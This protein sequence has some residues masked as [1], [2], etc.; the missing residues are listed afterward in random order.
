MGTDLKKSERTE[1]IDYLRG[2]SCIAVYL[3]HFVCIFLP[4]LMWKNSANSVIDNFWLGTPFNAITNGNSAVQFF[5]VVSGFLTAK[6]YYE[7]RNKSVNSSGL[8]FKILKLIEITTPAILFSFILM[9]F[10]RMYHIQAAKI[11]ARCHFVNCYNSF[12]PTY[13]SLVKD[14]F[15]VIV[16]NSK[17]NAPLGFMAINL[18]GGVLAD[19][20]S[21]AV[22]KTTDRKNGLLIYFIIW[23][24][25]IWNDQ[26]ISSFIVGCMVA[27]V[28]DKYGGTIKIWLL[29]KKLF[30]KAVILAVIIY[31][32]SFQGDGAGIYHLSDKI[33]K[34]APCIRSA[35]WGAILI[36]IEIM[37]SVRNKRNSP[38]MSILT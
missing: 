8:L 25:M 9:R 2:I 1:Y 14:I 36:W 12:A 34:Y 3:N 15:E 27:H 32:V 6:K 16:I 7:N 13:Q 20:I 10:N 37:Y 19:V 5:L 30:W 4:G 24:L 11:D 22:S 35:G 29:E 31:M 23:F 26:S 18:R 17:Y 38:K 21:S 28:V 33:L